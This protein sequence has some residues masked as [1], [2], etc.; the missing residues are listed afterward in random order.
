MLSV[1]KH[2]INATFCFLLWCLTR[3]WCVL[4]LVKVMN[5]KTYVRSSENE[6]I[7]DALIYCL[8]CGQMYEGRENT[9]PPENWANV[10]LQMDFID[11]HFFFLSF[12]P[13]LLFK[14]ISFKFNFWH[15]QDTKLFAT[16]W[17]TLCKTSIWKKCWLI[18]IT[19]GN[20]M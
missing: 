12:F 13:S 1:R 4:Q 2:W 8:N 18:N 9:K 10:S 19:V 17:R 5:A 14:V 16:N 11:N 6:Y 7:V 15:A 20:N 3:C